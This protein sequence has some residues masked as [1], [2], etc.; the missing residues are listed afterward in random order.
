MDKRDHNPFV[1]L[2]DTEPWVELPNSNDF[3][4]WVKKDEILYNQLSRQREKARFFVL[5]F[6]FLNEININGDYFEF[7]VHKCRTFRMALTEARRHEMN[8]MHF[9]AFDSFEGLPGK[10]SAK[11]KNWKKGAMQTDK[12]MFINLVRNHGILVDNVKIND[13]GGHIIKLF[14]ICFFFEIIFLQKLQACL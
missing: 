12:E 6:D 5:A 3:V 1:N 14:F 11:N 2:I 10:G 4:K 13:N 7:G 9:L 8:E